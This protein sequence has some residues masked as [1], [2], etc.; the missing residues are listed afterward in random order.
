MSIPGVDLRTEIAWNAGYR[1]PAVD[2][3]WTDVS[4]YVELQSDI[5]IE[6]GRADEI[7]ETDAN[8]LRLTFD[9]TDGRFTWGN[10]ASPYYPNV[11]IGRPIRV[12]ARI[13]GVDH[14]R[15]TGYVN[16][17]PVEWPG[18]G[19]TSAHAPVI[20][21][22]R[23]AR[24]GVDTP[25]VSTTDETIVRSGVKYYWPLTE[26]SESSEGA[27]F[28]RSADPITIL[29][30]PVTFG[31][32]T[33]DTDIAA[34]LVL[35][36]DGRP[37]VFLDRNASQQMGTIGADLRTALSMGPGAPGEATF[38]FYSKV[39]NPGGGSAF[40]DLPFATLTN[41]G[42][43]TGVFISLENVVLRLP[44]GTTR[45]VAWPATL[46]DTSTTRHI[47]ATL[48]CNGATITLAAYLDGVLAG[49]ASAPAEV[50]GL[51]RLR[52][53]HPEVFL[54][55]SRD[56]VLGRI[57]IW[58]TAL[59]PSTLDL[60]SDAGLT[61][62][63]GD[64]TNERAARLA[65]WAHIPAA[66]CDF[67]ASSITMTSLRAD[68]A[69]IV[70]LLRE[71]ETTEAGVLYDDR[72]GRLALR[73]RRART[74]APIALTLDLSKQTIGSDF[75]PRID[76]QGLV[77]IST[78]SNLDET[79][80][81]RVTDEESRQ[82][83]GDA[84]ADV[85]TAAQDPREPFTLA[86]AR[87]YA[88][89]NPRPRAPSA[90]INVL[91]WIATPAVLAQILALD[92]GSKVQFLNG[93]AQAPPTADTFFVEGYTETFGEASWD[94]ALNLSP[95]WPVADYLILDHSTYGRLDRGVLAI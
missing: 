17:W 27:E 31:V 89:S 28:T 52:A 86:A 78:G 53:T 82:E 20:G 38:A 95:G 58:D 10:P 30:P 56:I 5:G 84:S 6:Y 51:N 55:Y 36:V 34:G 83:Y 90:T 71:V 39:R 77:N 48:T 75:A 40:E 67:D 81:V 94:I 54:T 21:A 44:S 18:G 63:A 49:T 72:A 50:L 14:V 64:T 65:N 79:V 3:V 22:S 46:S 2:R 59:S 73:G 35:G 16:Q 93:P 61:A 70:E 37:A 57:G 9:N 45:T 33:R 13:N 87:V 80:E 43:S 8:Q 12:V 32:G 60:I 88:N 19:D 62:F 41:P 76:R 29:S 25:Q 11:K 92:I 23:L 74:L 24:L 68:G 42:A 26:P 91:D 7:A 4:R 66:E 15:A 69:Q 1:T 85:R 47:A